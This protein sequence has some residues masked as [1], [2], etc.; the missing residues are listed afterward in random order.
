[1]LN[2]SLILYASPHRNICATGNGM[3]QL[4]TCIRIPHFLAHVA[5]RAQPPGFSGPLVVGTSTA[6]RG[7]V[8]ATCPQASAHGIAVGM[9]VSEA[10]ARCPRLQVAVADAIAAE[11]AVTDVEHTVLQ[12]SNAVRSTSV[13]TWMV[14]LV[15]LG[16]RCR[17]ADVITR[18]LQA[19]LMR[20]T[21]LPC[22][23]GAGANSLVATVAADLAAGTRAQ[24]CVVLPGSEAAFLAPLPT[25]MLPGVGPHTEQTLTRLGIQTI[26]QLARV[27]DGPLRAQ[28]GTRGQTLRLRAQGLDA[29]TERSMCSSIRQRWTAANPCVDEHLLHA[30]VRVL[31]E[32]IGRRVRAWQ[33]AVGSLTVQLFWVD[34][35]VLHHAERVAPRCDL[36]TELAAIAHPLLV[37]LIRQ[38]QTAVTSIEVGATDLGPVQRDLFAPEDERLRRL[39]EAVDAVKRRYG[40]GAILVGS[41]IGKLQKPHVEP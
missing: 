2:T 36:D 22:V 19:D 27:A 18:Q 20:R 9:M 30:E 12:Y 37:Q 38:R 13:A 33:K 21:R 25:R 23:I 39:Q 31:I 24:R 15:A 1:M 4:T 34:G 17:Q 10:C 7:I 14:E 32:R 16:E 26:G 5:L 8:V 3:S 35:R 29:G 41:L 6:G 40:T 28:L 11:R